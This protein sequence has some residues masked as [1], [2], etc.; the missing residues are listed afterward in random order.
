MDKT[1]LNAPGSVV[2]RTLESLNSSIMAATGGLT[3]NCKIVAVNVGWI[4][5][6]LE[7]KL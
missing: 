4:Y 2:Y 1:L 6:Q 3:L 5:R 7:A